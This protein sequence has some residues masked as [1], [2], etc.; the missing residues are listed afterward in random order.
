MESIAFV[1][2][3]GA[4]NQVVLDALKAQ[5]SLS[6]VVDEKL[7]VVKLLKIAL[8]N[9]VEAAE[10]SA[11]WLP[12]TP[13]VDAKIGMGRQVGDESKHY[14]LIEERLRAMGVSLEGFD[15]L[16]DGY[17]PLYNYLATL[18]DTVSRVAAGQFTRESIALV[19]NRQFIDFCEATGDVETAALYRDIIQKD[20]EYHHLLGRTMLE[21]YAT[22]EEAQ[23][24]ARSAAAR[25]LE[26][27]EELQGL[28][29][30]K[31]GVHHAPGC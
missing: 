7:E 25:T 1:E 29:L 24:R 16:A 28:A 17:G 9:E 26:L 14:R 11:R 27:A 19:K 22:T 3:L 13:E 4:K 6:G 15:P 21:R 2:E 18:E 31:L 12:S 8:K 23:E 10:I 30:A 20:E 5:D